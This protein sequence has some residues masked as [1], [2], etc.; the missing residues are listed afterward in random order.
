MGAHCS[1][2][3]LSSRTGEALD[4]SLAERP[5]YSVSV[6]YGIPWR[7]ETR[8]GEAARTIPDDG[9]LNLS[10]HALPR[11]DIKTFF[12]GNFVNLPEKKKKQPGV[13]FQVP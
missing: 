10:T 9:Y 6:I 13:T 1:R 12:Y 11:P 4:D 3:A 5:L 2:R 7:Q 8:T